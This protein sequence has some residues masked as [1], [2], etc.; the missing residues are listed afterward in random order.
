MRTLQTLPALLK[1]IPIGAALSAIGVN[2]ASSSPGKYICPIHSDTVASLQVYNKYYG[3]CYGCGWSGTSVDLIQKYFGFADR[4]EAIQWIAERARTILPK[5]VAID[6]QSILTNAGLDEEQSL[7]WK[8]FLR[9]SRSAF[10]ESDSGKQV[11]DWVIEKGCHLSM[12]DN[13]MLPI[14]L[15]DQKY[16]LENLGQKDM[17]KYFGKYKVPFQQAVMF[18]Y[19]IM[20]NV[21]TTIKFRKPYGKSS[22]AMFIRVHESELGFF[23]LNCISSTRGG[24]DDI[25]IVVEGEFDAASLITQVQKDSPAIPPITC[26]SGLTVK[27]YLPQLQRMGFGKPLL[28][29]DNDP[30]GDR[31]LRKI[32]N[33]AFFEGQDPLI[34]HPAD[35][36]KDEDPAEYIKRY[37]GSGQTMHTFFT[38]LFSRESKMLASTYLA[39]RSVESVGTPTHDEDKWNMFQSLAKAI[40]DHRLTGVAAY[41]Y[42]KEVHSLLVNTP[43]FRG[44]S[45]EAL[46]RTVCA[47]IPEGH[48]IECISG[49]VKVKP[50]GYY[51]PP[52]NIDSDEVQL[53]NFTLSPQA[54]IDTP[55]STEFYFQAH[56]LTRPEPVI[57]KLKPEEICN[58]SQ[59]KPA[60]ISK[61]PGAQI[62]WVED[63]M[64]NFLSELTTRCTHMDNLKVYGWQ[65]DLKEKEFCGQGWRIKNGKFELWDDFAIC[66][67]LDH[68]AGFKKVMAA[69]T[70]NWG[71]LREAAKELVEFTASATSNVAI[72]ALL[73]GFIFSGL[74]RPLLGFKRGPL[75]VEGDPETGKTELVTA[76][77]S[78]FVA[79]AF[80]SG[81]LKVSAS[82]TVTAM[83]LILSRINGPPVI[84]DDIKRANLLR[85][86]AGMSQFNSLMQNIYD[87]QGRRRATP[88]MKLHSMLRPMATLLLTAEELPG[89]DRG[90]ESRYL[91]IPVGNKGNSIAV[92]PNALTR[93]A[94]R[95]SIIPNLLPHFIIYLSSINWKDEMKAIQNAVDIGHN[96]Q[97]IYYTTSLA[98]LN[99]FK[100]F[101]SE[102]VK[103]DKKTIDQLGHSIHILVEYITSI[104]KEHKRF[105]MSLADRYD[106]KVKAQGNDITTPPDYSLD[107]EKI[108]H[109]LPGSRGYD[110]LNEVAAHIDTGSF[111]IEGVNQDKKGL[112]VGSLDIPNRVVWL[113]PA[114][115]LAGLDSGIKTNFDA[116]SL[117]TLKRHLHLDAS[118]AE[119]MREIKSYKRKL[120]IPLSDITQFSDAVR[121]VINIVHKEKEGE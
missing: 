94:E 118:A 1:Q 72:S 92:N 52:K 109:Y 77:C 90:V 61:L 14:G 55:D 89:G 2:S 10:W 3:H 101:L 82:S 97:S 31:L 71:I 19:F 100:M 50:D 38:K 22:D 46:M 115:V 66:E 48:I 65:P 59:F 29:L 112:M 73:Q 21:L 20:P 99:Y 33:Q 28:W 34:I 106:E 36:K 81:A 120:P 67:T 68:I 62:N 15:Y 25:I 35:Y 80:E 114:R 117:T 47:K 7:F 17:K 27:N 53:T 85:S 8:K 79:Y 40:S 110:F 57:I 83:E 45:Q 75:V 108:S 84:Y 107:K 63:I 78:L 96:R 103:A 43:A 18:P 12:A 69:H 11:S 44:I 93:L 6:T 60:I 87:M 39:K 104:G 121:A 32:L 41:N 30:G 111:I 54:Q 58:K 119:A 95:G 88:G 116:R 113:E 70:E 76:L 9:L 13:F 56:T 4:R 24:A 42:I 98:G 23:A 26:C 91:A 74:I 49:K 102:Y 105:T 5:G 51:M 16:F 37:V 86:A 64:P